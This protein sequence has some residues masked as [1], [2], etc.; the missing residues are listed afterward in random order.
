MPR[1]VLLIDDSPAVRTLMRLALEREGYAV[2]EAEDGE[3]AVSLLDGRTVDVIVC[4]LNMPRMD[5]LSFMRWL[6][7]HAVY[8]KVPLAVLTTETRPHMKLAVN[9]GGA[10]AYIRKPCQASEFIDTV[11]RLC[12]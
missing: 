7:S 5:G 11:N 2:Q 3:A 4:D 10:N 12:H 9:T 1:S 8:R 6:R